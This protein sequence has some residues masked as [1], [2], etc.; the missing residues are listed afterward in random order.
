MDF[1]E[2]LT[3]VIEKGIT[4]ARRDYTRPD[5]EQKL[6][7]SI[8]GFE[9]CRGKNPLELKDLLDAAGIS[10]SDAYRGDDKAQYWWYRCYQAEVEWVC[11]VIS[12]ALYN[13][14]LPVIITPTCRGMITASEIVGVKDDGIGTASGT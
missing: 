7:G 4:A 8:A 12:A 14:G 13:Q 3:A 2:F 6:N 5:Q 1:F 11:N 10:V 9:A